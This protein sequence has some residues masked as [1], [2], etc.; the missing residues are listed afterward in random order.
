MRLLLDTHVFLWWVTESPRLSARARSRIADT[1]SEIRV[2]VVAI[3]EIAIKK[4]LDR[5]VY[6]DD[7]AAYTRE[8]FAENE[9]DVLPV[10][11]DHIFGLYGLPSFADHRDPFDRM[12]AA[13][14]MTE[15][16]SL[17]SADP[18]FDRYGIDRVW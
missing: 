1:G 4:R 5:L 15:G 16:L 9:F 2:S 7:F 17:V 18:N 11:L 14:A 3:W 6:P 10:S 8:Q 12:L 13:Q